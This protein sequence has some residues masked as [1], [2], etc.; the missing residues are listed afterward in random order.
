MSGW[1]RSVKLER[2]M[3]MRLY[4]CL[5]Y[6]LTWLEVHMCCLSTNSRETYW[7]RR[8]VPGRISRKMFKCSIARRTGADLVSRPSSVVTYRE[9][10]G[11]GLDTGFLDTPF[12]IHDYCLQPN[13][14][15]RTRQF[16]IY[17]LGLLSLSHSHS[18]SRLIW[19]PPW[20][21]FLLS[22]AV[23]SGALSNNWLL[24]LKLKLIFLPTVRRPVLVGVGSPFEAYDQL[25]VFFS[26]T[27]L[28]S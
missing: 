3:R 23:P 17:T 1:W 26:L 4:N 2:L 25:L 28:V 6:C 24:K 5:S 12:T 14:I 11:S 21:C 13:S 7:E 20:N 9:R 19:T 15:S 22:P 16:T 8:S 10:L 18:D 27:V